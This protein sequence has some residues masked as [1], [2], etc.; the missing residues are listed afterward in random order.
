[1]VSYRRPSIRRVSRTIQRRAGQEVGKRLLGKPHIHVK[2]ITDQSSN[3]SIMGKL[4]YSS[5]N[6]S[7]AI[8][9]TCKTSLNHQYRT[10]R[11]RINEHLQYFDSSHIE[12]ENKLDEFDI[13]QEDEHFKEIHGHYRNTLHQDSIALRRLKRGIA[14]GRDRFNL[15]PDNG[16]LGDIEEAQTDRELMR[17]IH[18]GQEVR[19]VEDPNIEE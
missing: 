14:E 6:I 18:R 8:K 1:M 13:S 11:R 4:H 19:H 16:E 7:R 10:F 2:G 3:E 12:A 9:E 15:S 5:P 17:E